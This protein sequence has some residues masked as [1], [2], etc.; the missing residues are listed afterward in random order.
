MAALL[1]RLHTDG[2]TNKSLPSP[3]ARAFV[4]YNGLAKCA[5]FIAMQAFNHAC[6]F[7]ARPLLVP[8]LE[9]LLG[10]LCSVQRGAW[11]A[12]IDLSNCSWSVHLPPTTAGAGR[13]A[14][15]GSTYALVHVPF[16][17][18]QVS[19]LFGAMLPEHAATQ[20]V[21]VQYP[22]HILFV[23]CDRLLT[24]QVARDTAAHL[25]CKGFLVSPKSVLDATQSLMWMGIQLCLHRPRVAHK[26]DGLADIVGCWVGFSLSCCT[27]KP[28]A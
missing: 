21:T 13:V 5:L 27:R 7:K 1:H 8:S 15:V 11:G 23:G 24:A 12:Q 22:N 18:H 2:V 25:A 16:G 6:S 19:G 26:P 3:N 9:D 17:W 28:R 4:K 10:L 20:V 14:A